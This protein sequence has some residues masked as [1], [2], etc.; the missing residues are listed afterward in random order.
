[1]TP[2]NPSTA[3]LLEPPQAKNGHA[4]EA[5]HARSLQGKIEV[6]ERPVDPTFQ[7]FDPWEFEAG[8]DLPW[9]CEQAKFA[10][11][12]REVS[13]SLWLARWRMLLPLMRRKGVTEIILFGHERIDVETRDGIYSTSLNFD[14]DQP[15]PEGWNKS[16]H[17]PG[18][19]D[20]AAGLNVIQREI[21]GREIWT[22]GREA[23]DVQIE[24]Q[25]EDGSRLE[26]LMPP[27][28]TNS[29]IVCNIRRFAPVKY[30][31]Y[32]F[33]G[34]E[35]FTER[36]ADV[37]EMGVQSKSTLMVGAE[38]G[39]G[40]TT[41]LEY[42]L[43]TIPKQDYPLTIEDTPEL[44]VEHPRHRGL[45]TRERLHGLNP[46]ETFQEMYTADLLRASLRLRPDWIIVG[47]IRDAGVQRSVADAFVN[48]CQTGHAG[49][50]TIH[51]DS[52]YGAMTRLESMLRAARP[53]MNDEALRVTLG[54]T[55]RLL[56][57]LK[58]M[59][60]TAFTPEGVERE[61]M[62]RRVLEIS[63]CL[64]SDGHKYFLNPIFATRFREKSFTTAAGV[65]SAAW[66]YL[67]QVGLPFFGLEL[68]DKGYEMPDWWYEAK[69]EFLSKIPKVGIAAHREFL[70]TF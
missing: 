32:D 18:P 65:K 24:A 17:R 21:V 19:E 57:I 41:L 63:E 14:R 10:K 55:V 27:C 39:A 33:I 38:T 11:W 25:L 20:L 23:L 36:A 4:H 37:M 62:L 53:N 49:A 2:T 54:D 13:E 22:K 12:S 40:K 6:L 9:L 15:T 64:G 59:R 58:K 35:S 8:P 68:E 42:L 61:V 26:A 1:M 7:R 69:L 30:R 47:E 48:A 45:K 51:A 44:Q 34:L 70:L 28:S 3:H 46:N 50:A 43:S 60:A 29:N 66:P 31:R 5:G 67:D 52:P 16:W 56:I